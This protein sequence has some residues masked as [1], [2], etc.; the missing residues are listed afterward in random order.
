MKIKIY[1]LSLFTLLASLSYGQSNP[2]RILNNI[3]LPKDTVIKEALL[4]SLDGFLRSK[5]S[6]NAANGFVS[7]ADLL[8]TSLLIDEMKSIEKNARSNSNNFYKPYLTNVIQRDEQTYLL[9][10]SYLGTREDTAILRGSFRLLARQEA[11]RFVFLSPLATN[12]MLWKTCRMDNVV[13]RYKEK[14]NLEEAKKL[15]QMLAYYDKKIGVPRQQI[16]FYCCDDFEEALKLIG[17]EYKAIYN[18]YNHLSL[19]TCHNN[20]TLIVSGMANRTGFNEFDP[21]DLWH[22]RLH[23]MYSTGIIN[24]PVD[25]GCA[26]LYG[27][28]WGIEWKEILAAFRDYAAKN[29]H[30][31]WLALYISEQNFVEGPKRLNIAYAINALI[32]QQLEK[33]KGFNAVKALLCCGKREK[34]DENYFRILEKVAGI[35]K[36]VFNSRV[37]RL[38]AGR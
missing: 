36:G 12:A 37:E 17:V 38:I 22:E 15:Q 28:S 4:R 21:H 18:G 6:A 13:F 19:Y 8:E 25:E 1:C 20:Q 14:I 7:K 26:Y 35:S 31:D 10:L 29:E 33:E 2:V 24:K 3:S 32:V 16:R 9:Q 5:D 34:G 27:G 30:A 11:D 23:N